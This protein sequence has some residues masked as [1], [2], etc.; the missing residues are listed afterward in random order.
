[1]SDLSLKKTIAEGKFLRFVN[2]DSWEYVERTNCTAVAAIVAVTPE[3]ELLLTEQYRKPLGRKVIELPA[4]LVNDREDTSGTSFKSLSNKPETIEE[5]A[6]RELLEETGYT[7]EGM[8]FLTEG[9]SSSGLSSEVQTLLMAKGLR[10]FS[11][12]GGIGLENIIVHKVPLNKI[13]DWIPV[14][15]KQGYLIDPKIYTGLF[16]IKKRRS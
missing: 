9:P 14:M 2:D 5:A 15:Q 10:K 4:G 8:I 6:K 12:G 1:M 13:E 11:E 7:A 3:D 16:F